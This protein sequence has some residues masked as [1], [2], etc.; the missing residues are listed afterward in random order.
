VEEE[1]HFRLVLE[2]VQE[3]LQ[4]EQQIQILEEMVDPLVEVEV[5][6]GDILHLQVATVVPES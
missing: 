4:E 2:V 5:E 6:V 3:L 1:G